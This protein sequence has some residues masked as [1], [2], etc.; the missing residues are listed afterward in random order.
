MERESAA[1]KSSEPELDHIDEDDGIEL[2]PVVE[3]GGSQGIGEQDHEE[4]PV[5]Y[6][7]EEEEEC[8]A[9]DGAVPTQ[10]GNTALA[11]P[12]KAV[13]SILSKGASSKASSV[14]GDVKP[15][16]IESSAGGS[17]GKKRRVPILALGVVAAVLVLG[18]LLIWKLAVY[19]DAPPVITGDLNL[20]ETSNPARLPN[21]LTFVAIGDW[22]REGAYGQQEIG[23]V[24][25]QWAEA[26]QS[27]FVVSVGDNFYSYGV[28]S[29]HDQQFNLSFADIYTHP[30]LARK[31]KKWK[32]VNG[33]HDWRGSYLQYGWKG[34]ERW[35]F[36]FLYYAEE[37]P[38]P[39]APPQPQ[40]G[41][42]SSSSSTSGKNSKACVQALFID[43]VPLMSEYRASPET[44]AMGQ[45]LNDPLLGDRNKQLA[46]IKDQLENKRNGCK[47][48]IVVGHH[49]VFSGGEHNSSPD[50]QR[51]LQPLL[52]ASGVHLVLAGHDHN[53]QL[54]HTD[55][56]N[57][58]HYIVT[59]A[60]SKI[61]T[62]TRHI[63]Q[64][65]WYADENGFTI[66]SINA[67]HMMN[68]FVGADGTIKYN[69]TFAL[70]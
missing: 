40:G 61:R 43:T 62:G 28:E 4:I 48:S 51:D 29:E 15:M 55:A 50:L 63:P 45:H 64:L 37:W 70:W 59:G 69:E 68:S 38:L 20:D 5:F 52:E 42:S 54:L 31:D 27:E 46:W 26:V 3:Q 21:S 23:E 39:P 12:K 33:N 7:D 67:T 14:D 35:S 8:A 30:Y 36:P 56:A 10:R 2:I 13:K 25:G 16:A 22:G 6:D 17:T 18:G 19:Y 1:L 9:Q 44:T 60:G 66:H 41:D 11:S 49:P 47:A 57:S 65:R 24:M 53:L 32:A 58:P 34:D